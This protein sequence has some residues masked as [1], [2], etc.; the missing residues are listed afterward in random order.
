MLCSTPYDNTLVLGYTTLLLIFVFDIIHTHTRD[1][2]NVPDTFS[3]FLMDTIQKFQFINNLLIILC[4]SRRCFISL[5]FSFFSIVL[6]VWFMHIQHQKR[7]SKLSVLNIPTLLIINQRSSSKWD[8]WSIEHNETL[9]YQYSIV[10]TRL[11][12]MSCV[13]WSTLLVDWRK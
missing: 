12:T 9:L 8:F 1:T 13:V 3:C 6:Y 5:I 4:R 7:P 10:P 11:Y 2:R